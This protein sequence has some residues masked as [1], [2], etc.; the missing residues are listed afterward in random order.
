M[1]QR[2]VNA[3]MKSRARVVALLAPNAVTP[4]MRTSLVTVS[5]G[6]APWLAT[7]TKAT[8]SLRGLG[9]WKRPF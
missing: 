5:R 7:S 1:S 6:R 3:M 4:R 8:D 9:G 2:S